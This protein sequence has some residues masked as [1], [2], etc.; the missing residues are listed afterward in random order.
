MGSTNIHLKV[1]YFLYFI[2][3]ANKYQTQYD[4]IPKKVSKPSKANATM[5]LKV[6]RKVSTSI[7]LKK[8][9]E[10]IVISFFFYRI[11][12]KRESYN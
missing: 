3:S 7:Y 4:T 5:A 10:F 8:F 6:V 9:K 2:E 12:L 1:K 11:D